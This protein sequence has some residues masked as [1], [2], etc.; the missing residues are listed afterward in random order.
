MVETADGARLD[1]DGMDPWSA[2]ALI[3]TLGLDRPAFEAGDPL[4]PFWHWLHFREAAPRSALGRDGHPAP[5]WSIPATGLPRRMWAGGR[6]VFPG[7][8]PLGAPARRRSRSLGVTNK[9]GRSGPLAFVTM[10]HD[11]EG[12]DGLAVRE[13]QDLVYRE[14]WQPGTPP[15]A[16]RSAPILPPDGLS[17]GWQLNA[18]ALFRYSALTFN[19]HR[20]HYDLA[21]ARE[22]EGYQGLVVHG[23]LLAT[24]MLELA[25]EAEPGR[26]RAF[27]GRFAFRAAS[28][29][30]ADE[31]FT[32]AGHARDRGLTLWVA[33]GDGRLAMTGDLDWAAEAL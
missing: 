12:P 28:P 26:M 9:T 5:G 15:P 11:I 4:P 27:R 19:G 7:P 10:Q 14:D 31:P 17:R 20:I 1:E 8:L 2:N 24:L 29:V 30:F 6:L 13:A 25:R 33:G 32:V 16:T 18:T 21:Y 22:V 23:P 3:A